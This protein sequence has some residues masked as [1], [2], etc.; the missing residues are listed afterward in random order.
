MARHWTDLLPS[1]VGARL[2]N[3]TTIKKD[4]EILVNAKWATMKAEGKQEA[5]FKKEDAL[6][7]ILDLLDCNGRYIDLT[8]DEYDELKS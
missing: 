5:G 6:V 2:A 4:I 7:Y 3:C 1:D 8:K